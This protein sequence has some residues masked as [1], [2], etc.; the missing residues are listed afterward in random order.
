MQRPSPSTAIACGA[1]I[2]F[3]LFIAGCGDAEE[4][5]GRI[6]LD[7][8]GGLPDGSIRA[9]WLEFSGLT[10][11][12]VD[13]QRV[14]HGFDEPKRIDIARLRRGNTARL[15]EDMEL[16]AGAYEWIQLHLNTRGKKDTYLVLA[17]NSIRELVVPSG[18]RNHLHIGAP[19][20][21]P[22]DGTVKRTIDFQLH[23]P[24][25]EKG[26]TTNTYAISPI[27]RS[28]ATETA[29]HIVAS[30]DRDLIARH[31]SEPHRSGIA[32]YV[33]SGEGVGPDDIGGPGP[34]PVSVS[35]GQAEDAEAPFEFHAAFLAPGPY[36]IALTCNA[37][38]DRATTDDAF[39]FFGTAV[40]RTGPGDTVKHHF[41]PP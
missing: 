36:T 29:S 4:S 9:A 32:L 3:A 5:P 13:G 12:R 11:E 34:R 35:R 8:T 14:Q 20:T 23:E 27:L 41:G 6:D 15:T 17:D 28:V 7:L 31:C 39:A 10:V 2:L 25:G 37:G 1:L 24:L 26:P 38:G 40:I 16:P 21:V 33:F 30:A 22:P 18:V 19:F